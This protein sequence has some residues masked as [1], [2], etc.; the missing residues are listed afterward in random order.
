MEIT[1]KHNS[2][3]PTRSGRNG[4]IDLMRF[5][6]CLIIILYHINNRLDLNPPFGLSEK[7]FSFCGE[8]RI[9]VDFSLSFRAIYLPLRQRKTI[10]QTA[11][12]PR[13]NLL[14]IA[15]RCRFFRIICLAILSAWHFGFIFTAC[16]IQGR[17]LKNC[18]I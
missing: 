16:R 10:R 2:A 12:P 3:H 7:Y 13:Q 5:V 8:G 14:C 11:L 17:Q 15:K 1:R 18:S 9:G 4:N 6:F